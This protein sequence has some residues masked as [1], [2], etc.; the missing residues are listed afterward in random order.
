MN[1]VTIDTVKDRI[2]DVQYVESDQSVI[3]IAT[4]KCGHKVI[5][6]AHCQPS[7]YYS[8]SIGKKEAYNNAISQ[9]F[10]LEVYYERNKERT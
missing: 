4:L 1:R 5:G 7:T 3:A 8:L 6:Q 9:I 10:D 2:R